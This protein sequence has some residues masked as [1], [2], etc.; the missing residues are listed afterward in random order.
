[1]TS[2]ATHTGEFQGIPPIGKRITVDGIWI[3]RIFAKR[4]NT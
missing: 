4:S 2:T 3:E 1:M